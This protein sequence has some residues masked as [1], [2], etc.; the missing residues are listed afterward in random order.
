M[1]NHLDNSL[2]CHFEVRGVFLKDIDLPTDYE[3][4]K[5]AILDVELEGERIEQRILVA[6]LPDIL[7]EGKVAEGEYI[8]IMH[9]NILKY[10]EHEKNFF[11]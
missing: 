1:L 5:K 8:L 3:K 4:L 10:L 7:V 11:R 6:S 2:L 9:Y